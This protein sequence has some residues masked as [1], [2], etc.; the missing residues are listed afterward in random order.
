MPLLHF[1]KIVGRKST[2]NRV[3]RQG[4]KANKNNSYETN[5]NGSSMK[6]LPHE[7]SCATCRCL[8]RNLAV[9]TRLPRERTRN[10]LKH[11][12]EAY[13]ELVA[14]TSKTSGRVNISARMRGSSTVSPCSQ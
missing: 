8:E 3:A 5:R 14:I 11:F 1:H 9:S 4:Q 12:H 13:R 6:L 10:A 2:V 7:P